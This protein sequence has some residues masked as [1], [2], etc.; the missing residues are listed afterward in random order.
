M[1]I[2]EWWKIIAILI[3]VAIA[4]G[5]LL[6]LIGELFGLSP[7]IRTGGI[8]VSVGIAAAFLIA[9]RRAAIDKHKNR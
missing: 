6:G 7:S 3:G 2:V 4:G 1:K 8:G 9:R 5:L